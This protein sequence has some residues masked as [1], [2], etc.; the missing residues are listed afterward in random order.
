[1]EEGLNV[2]RDVFFLEENICKALE[3]EKQPEAIKELEELC[4]NTA[5]DGLSLIAVDKKTGK[6][7]AASFNKLQVS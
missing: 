4:K 5:N 1:M 7:V 3:L 6:V 2:M